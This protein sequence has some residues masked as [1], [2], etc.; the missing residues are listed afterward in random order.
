MSNTIGAPQ[1]GS[2]KMSSIPIVLLNPFSPVK[3]VNL[4]PPY[5]L[6][7]LSTDLSP[8]ISPSPADVKPGIK[9]SWVFIATV[10]LFF[11][12]HRVNRVNTFL[13]LSS[14]FSEM[15]VS[16]ACCSTGW[17]SLTCPCSISWTCC[18]DRWVIWTQIALSNPLNS[19]V[20]AAS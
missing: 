20:P 4:A 10:Q 1:V 17:I 14:F 18:R 8:Q 2:E 16:C 19:F 3:L 9:D 11:S 7:T 5:V 15:C 6:W 13:I 12:G